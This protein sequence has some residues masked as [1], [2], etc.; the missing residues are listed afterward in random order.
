M[1]RKITITYSWEPNIW[2]ARTP[3]IE[4]YLAGG[5]TLNELRDRIH[6]ELPEFLG[7][8]LEITEVLSAYQKTA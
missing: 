1:A 6:S 2:V 7:E 5:E 8:K 3:D 4:N